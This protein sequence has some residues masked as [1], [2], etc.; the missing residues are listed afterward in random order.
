[1]RGDGT[2]RAD[3]IGI[4]APPAGRAAA[5]WRAFD[6]RQGLDRVPGWRYLTGTTAQLEQAWRAYGA[7]GGA[8]VVIDPAGRVRQVFRHDPRPG[9]AATRSS[10]AALFTDAARQ[11]LTER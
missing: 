1:M 4:P 11:A 3:L 6:R 2:G 9:T 10:F 5:S 7:G 8:V